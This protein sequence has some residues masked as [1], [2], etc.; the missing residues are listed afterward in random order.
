MPNKKKSVLI[1]LIIGVCTAFFLSRKYFRVSC[2]IEKNA[3]EGEKSLLG[4]EETA[5]LLNKIENMLG[6]ST[7]AK[8]P[9]I[10]EAGRTF[11]LEVPPDDEKMASSAIRKS[12]DSQEVTGNYN[13]KDEQNISQINQIP[14]QKKVRQEWSSEKD[15]LSDGQGSATFAQ[16]RD[17]TSSS[18][19]GFIGIHKTE[20]E[21]Q[22]KAA[23]LDV[24][25]K[26]NKSTTDHTWLD[27]LG[28]GDYYF[29]PTSSDE[30]ASDFNDNN[31]P[32]QEPVEKPDDPLPTTPWCIDFFGRVENAKEGS[33]VYAYDSEGKICGKT[34]IKKDGMYGILH[35]NVD[36][37][38]TERK[39]GMRVGESITFKVDGKTAS[40]WGPDLAVCQ[41]GSDL[42]QVNLRV[43]SETKS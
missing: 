28:S 14:I 29:T 12:D 19:G 41:G 22:P 6:K 20:N 10:K 25:S 33:W 11:H 35:I 8:K 4:S 43:D 2:A 26:A 5:L 30:Q 38:E 13:N 3:Q 18:H 36:D 31:E 34:K 15:E 40:T 7:E 21:L 42:K 37:L 32:E 16:V 9:D 17:E 23:S 27:H 24:T 1:M 39:E